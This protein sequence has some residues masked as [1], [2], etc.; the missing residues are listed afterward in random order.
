MIENIFQA[1]PAEIDIEIANLEGQNAALH[2]AADRA[3]RTIEYKYST[4][5]E[6]EQ[7]RKTIADAMTRSAVLNHLLRGL[8][9]EY[10]RR[11]GWARV[12]AVN[13]TSGHFHRSTACR[14]TY[15]TTEWIWMPELSGLTNAEVVERTGKMSCLT[16]FADQREEIEKG[17]E[18]TVFTPAQAKSREEREAAA[19]AK[20]AKQAK[21]AANGI[22][23]VDGTP[24]KDDDGYT[25]K[26]L[27]TAQI[28]A[29]DAL[30]QSGLDD[31]YA[32]QAETESHAAQLIEM[33]KRERLYAQ[34]LI[35]A[36][37]AKQGRPL[38]DVLEEIATKADKKLA[39]ARRD[40]ADRKA[41]GKT[42]RE[43]YAAK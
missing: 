33:S 8:E 5:T 24:L 25:I 39:P 2:A 43:W 4:N 14:N 41:A 34:R 26:T 27:R 42:A 28:K 23:D 19:A 20:A 37:A 32:D 11:G 30:E 22:T 12:Y 29:V 6:R 18:A 16:C 17:R 31:I 10:T 15:V 7:A 21:A 9:A 3:H 1:S 13:N 35:K 40:E 36:I 38:A